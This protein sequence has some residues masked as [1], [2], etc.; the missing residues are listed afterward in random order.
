MAPLSDA[1]V[2]PAAGA[3]VGGEAAG[4]ATADFVEAPM[5]A[6]AEAPWTQTVVVLLALA[7]ASGIGLAAVDP[8][9]LPAGVDRSTELRATSRWAFLLDVHAWSAAFLILAASGLILR[10]LPDAGRRPRSWRTAVVL[11]A[12]VAAAIGTGGALDSGATWAIHCLVLPVGT[13]LAAWRLLASPERS[14]P[15]EDPAG[16]ASA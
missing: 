7:I 2:E 9:P 13:A 11:C 4:H 1:V 15:A 16:G 5:A 3:A 12:L 14:E 6:P 10:A 8:G